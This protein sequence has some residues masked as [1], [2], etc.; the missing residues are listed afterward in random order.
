M[1]LFFKNI[2]KFSILYLILY[3]LDS[4]LK[5]NQ[6]LSPYRYLSKTLLSFSLLI[7]YLLNTT[8][9]D[10]GKKKL[11]IIALC[12]F[13]VGDLFFIAGNRGNMW[14]FMFAA[15]LFIIA[16]VCYSVR[17]FNN[18]DF[19]IS[20]LI[21]FLLFCFCYMSIIMA[22]VYNQLGVFFIPLLIYLFVVMLLMQFAYLRKNEVNS[23]S[24][25]F[26]IFGVIASMIADS[27]DI[28][29]M[30][31][32]PEMAYNKITIMFFYCLSQYLIIIGVL[33]E[34]KSSANQENALI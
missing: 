7:F 14:H 28:L 12:C 10:S 8:Q 13:A 26:V 2:L 3:L 1:T 25:W 22:I 17:F 16:K 23:E 6:E 32:D 29:K 33:K 4:F 11:I 31:Y 34:T 5:N 27:L 20:K 18:K 21:P 30:F 9:E 15:F 24:F 19:K